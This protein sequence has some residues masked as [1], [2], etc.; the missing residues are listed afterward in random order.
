ME[1][2][3]RRPDAQGVATDRSGGR[4][5]FQA[6][7]WIT[8][9]A[10]TLP[11]APKRQTAGTRTCRALSHEWS[12]PYNRPWIPAPPLA[13]RNSPAALQV[14]TIAPGWVGGAGRLTPE[15]GA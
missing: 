15:S 6:L 3:W 11:V 12:R 8:A 14:M 5:S 1:S 9:E 2:W 13:K 4:R 7:P 10:R